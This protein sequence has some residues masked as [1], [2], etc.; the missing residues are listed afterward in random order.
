MEIAVLR[1]LGLTSGGVRR[2]ALAQSAT[3][4]LVGIGVGIPFGVIIGRAAWRSYANSIDIVPSPDT[5][6]GWL[7]LF[8]AGAA[9]IVLVSAL[10]SASRSVRPGSASILAAD[11]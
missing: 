11:S 2:T 1:S 8:V 3:E 7:V 4:M 5:Q 6:G 10:V 9:A